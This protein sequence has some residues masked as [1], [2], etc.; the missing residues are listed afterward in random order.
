M[1]AID[2]ASDIAIVF[3]GFRSRPYRCPAGVPTIGYGTTHYPDG[4][5]VNMT[6]SSID[7]DTALVYL[8]LEL[9]KSMN[10]ALRY[11]PIL[12]TDEGKLAA[13]IDFCYNL[14]VGRLQQSTLRRRINQQNWS[15]C[16]TELLRWVFA[17]GKKLP[18]LV[19]RRSLEATFF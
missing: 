13:I 3:E 8:Q 2:I 11:C 18:G 12:S 16:K 10:G 17:G 14:G 6:D 15:S 9:Q 4:R 5:K 7:E 1:S 19:K